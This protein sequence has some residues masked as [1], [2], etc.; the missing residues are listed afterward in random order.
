[1]TFFKKLLHDYSLGQ[2]PE[3]WQGGSLVSEMW[4]SAKNY[5]YFWGVQ[6]TFV[7]IQ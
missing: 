4:K 5:I 7:N 6:F 3:I 1:M 2:E